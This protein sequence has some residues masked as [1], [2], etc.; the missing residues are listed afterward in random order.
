MP[1]EKHSPDQD[2][3]AQRKTGVSS[4]NA[5]FQK[6]F[7]E[8]KDTEGREKPEN[9]QTPLCNPTIHSVHIIVQWDA[10][11][12]IGH[13]M[14]SQERI[15]LFSLQPAW[16]REKGILLTVTKSFP[17][18]VA[19]ITKYPEGAG[20]VQQHVHTH[21]A[22]L[23]TLCSLPDLATPQG[24]KFKTI[25]ETTAEVQWEPFSFPFDGWEISFIPKVLLPH[26]WHCRVHPGTLKAPSEWILNQFQI[27]PF[28]K[29]PACVC[30]LGAAHQP[31]PDTASLRFL[32]SF[33][34]KLYMSSKKHPPKNPMMGKK[35]F[36]PCCLF[37]LSISFAMTLSPPPLPC[38]A[39][40][41][42]L[43]KAGWIKVSS[44]WLSDNNLQH[45]RVTRRL[46]SC[47]GILIAVTSR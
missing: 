26:P 10:S 35:P 42:K 17:V 15:S 33:C 46:N 6:G 37:F 8:T 28:P 44:C 3:D 5:S 13:T 31:A 21:P 45:P 29:Y 32:I 1:Q 36:Q 18:F 19:Q 16:S 11:V 12:S 39:L 43:P 24:L 27:T 4:C 20:W 14:V 7:S 25:T 2:C 41:T 38:P 22:L 9:I 23:I 30:H 34:V 40:Y 47:H